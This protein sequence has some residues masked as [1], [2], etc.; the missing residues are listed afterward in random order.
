MT[1]DSFFQLEIKWTMRFV[2]VLTIMIYTIA[3]CYTFGRISGL[4]SLSCLGRDILICLPVLVLSAFIHWDF[5]FSFDVLGRMN[6]KVRA[7]TL[8][9]YLAPVSVF[10]CL[11]LNFSLVGRMLCLVLLVAHPLTCACI[12]TSTDFF[13]LL[14]TGLLC[15][16]IL[17][18]LYM[19]V[20]FFMRYVRGRFRLIQERQYRA[21][22]ECQLLRQ[23][24][25]PHFLFNC[26]TSAAA[27][28]EDDP[29]RAR[30]FL[31]ELASVYRYIL[32][33]S[34]RRSVT[35]DEEMNFVRAYLHLQQV[36][37]AEGLEV[38]YDVDPQNLACRVIPGSVQML[39]ENALKHN[40]R[41]ADSP[42]RIRVATTQDGVKVSNNVQRREPESSTGSGLR[43]LEELHR[44][45]GLSVRISDEEDVFSVTIP[46]LPQGV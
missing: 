11:S 27:L 25:D 4:V 33:M 23:Q 8:G 20:L 18:L 32:G 16:S 29:A 41:T 12:G 44:R 43:I 1:E 19:V 6:P 35:L 17:L 15:N 3:A 5:N 31:S 14:L 30:T 24:V 9:D 10:T 42:L 13:D 34:E 2:L 21:E 45:Y 28:T 7:S 36:R 39:V 46:F 22:F 37:F 40:T 26:L 38:T